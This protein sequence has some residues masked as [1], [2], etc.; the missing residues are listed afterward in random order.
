[1]PAKQFSY[2]QID[3]LVGRMYE[4]CDIQMGIEDGHLASLDDVL[5]WVKKRSDH[6]GQELLDSGVRLAGSRPYTSENEHEISK[7]REFTDPAQMHAKK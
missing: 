5:N 1:M 2:N 7:T 3:E 6:I 4:C